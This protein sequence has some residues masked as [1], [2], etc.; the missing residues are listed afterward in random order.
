MTGTSYE[1]AVSGIRAR[2]VEWDIDPT[3]DRIRDLADILGSPQRAYPVIHVTGT[4]GKSSTARMI[5][6]LLR[7]RGLRV[8][9]YT[10]PELNT[11]RERIAVDGRPVSAER[12][13][14][15]Y[16]DVLP[17]AQMIDAKHEVK[18]SFFEMLTAMAFSAFADAPVDVAVIEVGMGGTWDATN[19]AD[20]SVAVVTPIGLDHTPMLGDSIAE[21]ATEKAGI[22]KPGAVAILA[23]QPVEAA[24]VLVR[25]ATEVGAV[26]AREGLEFG[27]LQREL[28]VGGQQVRLQGLH[29]VYDDVFLP[30]FGD[31]QADNAVCALAAV[32]A[33]ASGRSTAAA[34]P[35]EEALQFA[36][37][38]LDPSLVRAAF[39]NAESPGRLEVVRTGPTVLVDAAHNPA[40][41]AATVGA[42]TEEFGFTRLIG[43]LAVMADK[44]VTGLL[45]ELEPVVDEL[46][47]TRNS[48]P[49]SMAAHDLA[50]VA[51]DV[52]GEDRV[53]LVPRL[54]DAID[55][56]IGLADEVG[57]FAGAGVLITG[58]VA[59][60]GD[61][62][63]LMRAPE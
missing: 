38:Q 42:L 9:L 44:D 62:R 49:R 1:E 22:I 3:L 58:S 54:D 59:T 27:V 20:G 14:E 41:M 24:E 7:E 39:V 30:M 4:N 10:S 29:G 18:V 34:E 5:D 51:Q 11:M 31:Y 43:I 15:L 36:P 32:E 6:A 23:Q 56:G 61:A 57:E 46:I 12:F 26:I 40:G 13:A 53:H 35:G 37:D 47:V 60:A 21:I 45:E 16:D 8:G 19:V 63:L 25:R 52:F 55:K 17:F 28:A 50:A 2:G 48:S 33:F